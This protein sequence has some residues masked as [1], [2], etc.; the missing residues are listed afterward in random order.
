MI[1]E[2]IV[3]LIVKRKE[4][5]N[6]EKN[7]EALHSVVEKRSTNI[8]DLYEFYNQCLINKGDIDELYTP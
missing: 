4:D 1:F 2:T 5:L 6:M 3:S 7:Y 8:K